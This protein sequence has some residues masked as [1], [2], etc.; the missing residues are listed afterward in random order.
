M[1]ILGIIPTRYA[2]SRFPGKALADVGGKPML[3]RV[4]EQTKLSSFLSHL[5]V[6][7]D[8]E[9]IAEMCIKLDIPVEMTSDYHR[10]GTDRCAEV[11]SKYPEYDAI[12]SIHCDEPFIMSNQIDILAKTLLQNSNADIATLA[13]FIESREELD[14][15]E[16]VKIVFGYNQEAIY[17]SR[18]P[19]PYF[20]HASKEE[21]LLRHQYYKHIGLYA[22]KKETLLEIAALNVSYLETAENVEALRWIENDY[23]VKVSLT[24]YDSIEINTPKDLEELLNNRSHLS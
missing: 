18:H 5:I 13:K 23:N 4:Y 6:A 15:P 8:D 3:Q 14:D 16:V 19:I 12:I 1:Q 2:S 24:D 17:M 21:W 9:R 22:F 7:T 20:V 11:A 10:S